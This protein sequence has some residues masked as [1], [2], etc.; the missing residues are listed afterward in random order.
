MRGRLMRSR[1]NA[2]RSISPAASAPAASS[3]CCPS[4]SA[5]MAPHVTFV[6]TT[7]DLRPFAAGAIRSRH[8]LRNERQEAARERPQ[9]AVAETPAP[10]GVP[11]RFTVVGLKAE[12]NSFSQRESN[13]SVTAPQIVKDSQAR[14]PGPWKRA[15][16]GQTEFGQRSLFPPFDQRSFSAVTIQGRGHLPRA[17]ELAMKFQGPTRA[18]GRPQG[19]SGRAKIHVST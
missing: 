1:G 13:S 11:E 7:S 4:W 19:L 18:Q 2:W 17:G 5:C 10:G 14:A 3:R 6:P 8:R 9:C 12:R 16:S 15:I